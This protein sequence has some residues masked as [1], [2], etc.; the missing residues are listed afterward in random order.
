V[1]ATFP[2]AAAPDQRL[3]PG[4]LLPVILTTVSAATIILLGALRIFDGPPV[5]TPIAQVV[6]LVAF[7]ALALVDYRA[8]VAIVLIEIACLGASGLWTELPGGLTGRQALH[9]IVLARALGLLLATWRSEGRI[10]LG[11][12]GWHA[13]A[14]AIILPLVWMPLGLLNGHS[15]SDVFG[16][17]NAH[18]FFA[19]TLV[20]IALIADGFGPW[21]RR[22]LLIACAANAALTGLLILVTVTN[23]L[24]ISSG[25]SP[26]VT[27]DLVMGGA[28]GYMP[29]GAYR[30]Y[31]GS[32]LYLQVGVALTVW[33]L[34]RQPRNPW[35]WGL[36][37]LLLVDIAATYTRGFWLGTA[38]AAGIVLLVGARSA[39]RPL[40]I[41]AGTI[42]IFVAA[43]AIGAV[44]SFSV[45]AYIFDRTASSFAIGGDPDSGPDEPPRPDEEDFLGDAAGEAS[46]RVKLV[47]A[48][49]LIGH[50]VE[51]PLIGHG[52][53]A[54]AE[55][56]PYGQIYSYELAFLDLAYKAGLVGLA[57]FLS[58]P[59]RLVFDAVRIRLG[60]LRAP[61][62][63][64]GTS[65][66][67]MG[68]VLA[69][70]VSVLITSATN[71]YILASFGMLPVLICVAWLEPMEP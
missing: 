43:T 71:P 5:V 45:P 38:L 9:A 29:N 17:G 60:I 70:V 1:R 64:A 66:L 3:A 16:D 7:S 65:R 47:Q 25:L 56:Y 41:I 58:F 52:F 48:E 14:L 8:A 35:L 21:L 63:P 13:V 31:L 6:L 44:M 34:L 49:V 46:N 50:I 53:G 33:H 37:A 26:I 59:L 28:V 32:G 61:R 55:D 10:Q 67:E 42:V 51:S 23:L 69:I 11:R 36:Y 24:P 4:N 15:P 62:P 30:L 68:V 39:R 19:F 54:I 2:V 22:W 18:L 27:T 57:L 40:A 20:F 12:Y